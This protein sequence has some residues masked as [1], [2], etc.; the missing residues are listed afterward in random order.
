M[1]I[2]NHWNIV[3]A[4]KAVNL[5][6][7]IQTSIRLLLPVCSSFVTHALAVKFYTYSNIFLYC[8]MPLVTMYEKL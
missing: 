6:F 4:S 8:I 3:E 2:F 7:E 5:L 1:C